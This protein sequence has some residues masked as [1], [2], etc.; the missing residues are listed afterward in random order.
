MPRPVLNADPEFPGMSVQK[1]LLV[2]VSFAVAGILVLAVFGKKQ[3]D[4]IYDNAI[5]ASNKTIPGIQAIRDARTHAQHASLLRY[6]Q[7][8]ST[9]KAV[10]ADLGQQIDAEH[11]NVR[12]SLQRYEA[13]LSNDEDKRMLEA[14]R[15]ALDDLQRVIDAQQL[16]YVGGIASDLPQ[17]VSMDIQLEAALDAH[18]LYSSSMS[19]LLQKHEAEAYKR[20]VLTTAVFVVSIVIVLLLIGYLVSRRIAWQIG[21]TNELAQENAMFR[22]MVEC[23]R[24]QPVTVHDIDGGHRIV[25]ANAAACKHFGVD[26][27]TLLTW[28]P[29]EFDS[30]VTAEQ[31]REIENVWQE[32]GSLLFETLHKIAKDELAPVEVACNFFRHNDRRL[33][34]CFTR[35]LRPQRVS[36]SRMLELQ[37][38]ETD[39]EN[40][41]RLTRFA[42]SAPG[43]MYTVEQR[44]DGSAAMIYASPAVEN[45][46]GLGLADVLADV[47]N[48]YALIVPEDLEKVQKLMEESFQRQSPFHA[49]YRIRHSTKGE[50]WME[51]TSMPDAMEDGGMQWHGFVTDVTERKQM[52]E[53][54]A[55]RE[56][57]FRTLCENSPDMIIRYDLDCRRIYVNRAFL[58]ATGIPMEEALGKPATALAWWS[59]NISAQE[60]EEHLRKVINTGDALTIRLYGNSPTSGQPR[61]AMARIVP[62]YNEADRV[63]SLLVV[64]RDVTD[65][66]LAEQELRQ[67]EQYQR[68]LLDNFPFFVWLKDTDHRLLAAN[69][70]YAKIAKVATTFELEGKTDFDFFP[71][72]LAEGYVEDDRQVMASGEPKSVVEMFKDHQGELRWMETYKSPVYVDSQ[73]VGTVGFSRDVTD[74]RRLELELLRSEREFRT[75]VENSPDVIIRYDK[76]CRRIYLSDS[77][78][79]V[80]G[81]AKDAAL[82]KRPTDSWGN[83]TMNPAIYEKKLLK[84]MATG[85]PG[86]IELDWHGTDGQY[87]CQWLRVVPEFNSKGEM[88]GALS[89]SRD[90]S[91]IRRV[92][93]SLYLREQELRALIDHTPDTITRYDRNCRRV[94]ANPRMIEDSAVPM[95]QMIGKKPTEYPGG[96]SAEAYEM[97]IRKV[98]ESGEPCS[99]ELTWRKGNGGNGCTHIRL[100]PERDVDGS[101]RSVLAVGRDIT[102]I[103]EYRQRIHDLAFFD[104]L[105]RLPNRALLTERIRQAFAAAAEHGHQ[106]GLMMLDLDRFKEINDTL[107]HAIGDELLREVA[108]RLQTSIRNSDTVARLG[109]D[110][111]AVLLPEVYERRDLDMI[112]RK[113]IEVF[114][115]PF[116]LQGKELF[117]T[118]SIGVAFY[119]EDTTEMETLYKYADSAMYHAKKQGR[120]NF[121][122]YS[123]ELT[124]Q[125]SER[126]TLDT[127]LRKAQKRGELE[128]YYQPQVDLNTGALIGAEA[129]LRW[130]HR[131]LGMIPPDKFISLAEETGVIIEIGEWVL[132]HACKAA[133]VWNAETAESDPPFKVAVNLSTRQFVRNDLVGSIRRIL[134]ETKC[135]A[136]WIKL[137]ITESLL[138]DDSKE[139]LD[140]LNTLSGMG[141]DI[142]IDDFGTGYSALSYL[143][144]FP[145]SQI[146]IDRSFVRHIP[147]DTDKSELVKAIIR[148]AD[149]MRLDLVAEGVETP[150]QAYYLSAN[151]CRV[152]QGY[153][154]GK[155]MPLAEFQA[156]MVER[157]AGVH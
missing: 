130:K 87:F 133:T 54:L 96:E 108:K 134:A 115:E 38:M 52:E 86:E 16:P 31:L 152:V 37:R 101:V 33:Y 26:M 76:E 18:V 43:F 119:P 12:A 20:A 8:V 4:I 61:H 132:I 118:T 68:A 112:A 79:Q 80:F 106:I 35:D 131:E 5:Y 99:F 136:Q 145:V 7:E 53:Q 41:R 142:S 155:P 128:L 27:T 113:I 28:K 72:E 139:T 114:S 154:F 64:V 123:K 77:Y 56:R 51:A 78:E 17:Q 50:R 91:E 46:Y 89:I 47:G 102:E 21:R 85:Q 29:A 83:P 19:Q 93:K 13:L 90:I 67:R 15:Q 40:V 42:Q 141:L 105:S 125:S 97:A 84:V 107:G 9:D 153:L 11:E 103:D 92:E 88:R 144:R 44:F 25:Y 2:L 126:M 117:V 109:G 10:Q 63:N 22:A 69:L 75:L 74:Q 48:I 81:L 98:I 6:R 110:E 60:F 32:N 100:T 135:K 34:I 58:A 70:Q 157:R 104:S 71:A 66:A 45:I 120:N 39:H 156:L 59:S 149:T 3:V 82:H 23:V 122:F 1:W 127:A 143:N 14:D 116:H 95:E 57:E 36:E 30:N 138:L 65:L 73:V 147:D 111:F 94:F 151:G 62:E 146:K 148:I 129:L 49:Q 24:D 140:A 137:E 55:I 121:Q 124:I 150:Q